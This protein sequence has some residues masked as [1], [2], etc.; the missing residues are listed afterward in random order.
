MACGRPCLPR[1]LH[2]PLANERP[3][4]DSG[5]YSDDRMSEASC[6]PN[7]DYIFDQGC[8]NGLSHH[9]TWADTVAQPFGDLRHGVAAGRSRGP[10]PCTEKET[11]VCAVKLALRSMKRHFYEKRTIR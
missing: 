8:H 5:M 4:F 1:G 6:R 7:G 11:S 10:A 9:T 3:T 2:Y